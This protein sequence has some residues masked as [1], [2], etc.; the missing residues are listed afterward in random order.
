V[1]EALRRLT[2]LPLD[3][4]LMI[5]QPQRYLRQF[6]EAGADMLTV[7][8]EALDEPEQ[9]LA[10][11]KDLGAAAGIA[12]NP[13]TPSQRLECCLAICD[14]ALVMS[15]EAGFGGQKFNPVALER[16]RRYRQL[17]GERV[18]LEVDGGINSA[19]IAACA[20]AGADLFVVGSAIFRNGDYA[21]AVRELTELASTATRK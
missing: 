21:S 14:A 7:H 5:T 18:L 12:L 4:H 10:E 8:V 13:S 19:T 17:A 15:V 2:D 11:I 6:Y 16:L 3:A 9:V 20:E 1:V